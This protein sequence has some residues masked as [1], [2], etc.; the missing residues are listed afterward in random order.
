LFS[1]RNYESPFEKRA[2]EYGRRYQG[3]K[4]DD[5]TIAIGQINLIQK[6]NEL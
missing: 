1:C 4:S 3:G 6:K 2:R 5:I